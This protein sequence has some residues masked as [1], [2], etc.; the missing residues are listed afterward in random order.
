MFAIE[1]LKQVK[2][3]ALRKRR[4]MAVGHVA[5]DSIR[6]KRLIL[7]MRALINAG[8][9]AIAPQLRSDDWLAR[10]EHDK[11]RQILVLRTQAKSQPRAQAGPDRL[12]VSRVHH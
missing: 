10:T 9:K 5:D 3:T 11:A 6:I 2:L 8:Q 1:C 12:H 7:N 4:E